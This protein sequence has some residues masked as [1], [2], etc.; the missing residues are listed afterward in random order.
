MRPVNLPGER[1]NDLSRALDFA[2]ERFAKWLDEK[3]LSP[4]Q[5]QAIQ[6]VYAARR[7]TW[8]EARSQGLEVPSDTGLPEAGPGESAASRS[9]RYWTYVEQEIRRF[10]APFSLA[11][12]H[13]L[14]ADVRER[15]VVLERERASE[16][17]L[18]VPR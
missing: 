3:V 18:E 5:M 1:W 9:L 2:E 11:Q 10:P 14:S 12:A 16:E 17:P 4:N 13:A 7:K 6:K 8:A 15:R